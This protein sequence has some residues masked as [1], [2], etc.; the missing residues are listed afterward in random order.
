MI[1][2]I[3]IA[4]PALVEAE[5]AYLW[6][7]ARSPTNADR[8][9]RRLRATI[10]TLKANPERFALAP[11]ADA[12]AVPIRQLL[13]GKRGGVY[14]ILFTVTESTVPILHIRHGAR[15]FL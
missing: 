12:F 7:H 15:R 10:E 11:E 14:R 9:H 5:E 4:P 1:Y 8:W 2:E 3:E 13:F 6:I